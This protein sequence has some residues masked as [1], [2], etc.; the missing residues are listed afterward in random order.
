MVKPFSKVLWLFMELKK[1]NEY[2]S[3][4]RQKWQGLTSEV[5]TSFKAFKLF[6]T[7]G[8]GVITMEELK[9]LIGK[10]GGDMSEAEAISHIKAAD[11]DGNM[12]IDFAEFGKLWAALHGAEEV[13]NIA[14]NEFI[15][16]FWCHFQNKIRG[17]FAKLDVDKSGYI[18][19]GR[20]N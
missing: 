5:K 2:N 9:G 18:T 11:A 4:T 20:L 19:K 3:F 8:D 12:A 1:P 15:F 17:E 16:N 13:I 7:D 6:D 14:A 10:V